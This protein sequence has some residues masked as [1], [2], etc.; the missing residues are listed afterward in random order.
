MFLKAQVRIHPSLAFKGH[1]DVGTVVDS[2]QN[3]VRTSP[4]SDDVDAPIS[5]RYLAANHTY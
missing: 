1:G 5:Q 4:V 3:R 2:G